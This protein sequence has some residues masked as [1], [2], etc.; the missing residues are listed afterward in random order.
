[1]LADRVLRVA[2][3]EVLAGARVVP[4]RIDQ[5]ASLADLRDALGSRVEFTQADRIARDEHAIAVLDEEDIDAEVALVDD[6][7]EGADGKLEALVDLDRAGVL[8][9]VDALDESPVG[10]AGEFAL[11]D[12]L[13]AV[14]G[15]HEV[16]PREGIVLHR[17]GREEKPRVD[18]VERVEGEPLLRRRE[19]AGDVRLGERRTHLDR[20][21]IG[22]R[23]ER[24][25]ATASARRDGGS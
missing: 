14:A 16:D 11:G 5:L 6:R 23:R 18:A 25:D 15:L 22:E 21:L 4:L 3:G 9:A 13:E 1:M 2:R 8:D 7:V 10:P 17:L 24:G 19:R 20:I 12:P